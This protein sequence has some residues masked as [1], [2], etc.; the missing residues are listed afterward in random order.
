MLVALEVEARRDGYV[1][2]FKEAKRRYPALS[3]YASPRE[4]ITALASDAR[5]RLPERELIVWSLVSEQRRRPH[6][7]W[8]AILA[9]AFA[10]MLR[11]LRAR[12]RPDQLNADELNQLVLTTF[13]FVVTEFPGRGPGYTAI[14]LRQLTRRAVVNVMRAADD[15]YEA[16][17]PMP[18]EGLAEVGHEHEPGAAFCGPLRKPTLEEAD[19]LFELLLETVG[20]SVPADH[21]DL[22]RA[23]MLR[24]EPL[25]DYVRRLYPRAPASD[26]RRL[27]ERVKRRRTRVIQRMREPLARLRP[28]PEPEEG[29][30]A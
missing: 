27:Y 3:P 13:L 15:E 23:T 10:P 28:E 4:V 5:R 25:E 6:P 12:L 11:L 30:G 22:V 1:K 2:R 7:V 19:A 14:A 26:Q 29:C 21:L 20:T 16:S 24:G 17:E 18:P 8:A 9:A